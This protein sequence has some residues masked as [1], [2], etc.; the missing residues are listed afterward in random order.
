M[1][2]FLLIL[3]TLIITFNA[4]AQDENY[5]VEGVARKSGALFKCYLYKGFEEA[6]RINYE[7][8]FGDGEV[9][10]GLNCYMSYRK[11]YLESG[12]ES[13]KNFVVVIKSV[14]I[15][16][17]EGNVKSSSVYSEDIVITSTTGKILMTTAGILLAPISL[18]SDFYARYLYDMSSFGLDFDA[19]FKNSW[20]PHFDIEYGASYRHATTDIGVNAAVLLKAISNQRMTIFNPYIGAGGHYFFTNTPS[21]DLSAMA[22]ITIGWKFYRIDFRYCHGYSIEDK[23]FTTGYIQAGI[24]ITYQSKPFGIFRYR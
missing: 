7:V 12:F 9:V 4:F 10:K 15:L 2:R 22:G 17:I 19:G 1:K 21:Y 24:V 18:G 23:K 3:L 5:K 11:G 8:R 14:F 13:Q 16:D 20:T 6:C